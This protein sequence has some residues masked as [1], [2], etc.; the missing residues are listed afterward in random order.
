MI[1][2]KKNN[3][4]DRVFLELQTKLNLAYWIANDAEHYFQISKNTINTFEYKKLIKQFEVA[5][6]VAQQ[7]E[8]YKPNISSDHKNAIAILQDFV[9]HSINQLD[10]RKQA[11]NE[12]EKLDLIKLAREQEQFNRKFVPFLHK[13][14]FESYL[15]NTYLYF[16][17]GMLS[18]VDEYWENNS[19]HYVRNRRDSLINHLNTALSKL[20]AGIND[21]EALN[22]IM[23]ECSIIG[24]EK[25]SD[26]DIYKYINLHLDFMKMWKEF[27]TTTK[28][29]Y[30]EIFSN[31]PN[32]D[33]E[34]EEISMLEYTQNNYLGII[35]ILGIKINQM[36][37]DKMNIEFPKTEIF[38][39]RVIKNPLER[40]ND[41]WHLRM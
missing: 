22:F 9:I 7:V 40:I 35:N 10:F 27:I 11:Y 17:K 18:L 38:S 16:T 21:P 25:F 36:I 37:I 2:Y 29:S 20:D 30:D 1:F 12:D 41:K 15:Q 6:S 5:S 14:E 3:T 39:R 32:V 24:I 8:A 33:T 23:D 13:R 31:N 4:H 26:N 19:S 34:A 28:N